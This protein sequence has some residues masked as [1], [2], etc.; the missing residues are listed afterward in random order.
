M[1]L[2]R[3]VLMALVVGALPPIGAAFAAVES[4]GGGIPPDMSEGAGGT[5]NEYSIPP[6][7]P[8]SLKNADNH[9]W[10][11]QTVKNPKG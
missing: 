4:E 1:K 3:A 11:K 8:K 10:K 5:Q 6:V 7:N 2:T 9:P